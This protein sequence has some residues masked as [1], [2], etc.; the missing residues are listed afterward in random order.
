MDEST[1]LAR[2]Q[3][4][5]AAQQRRLADQQA[6]LGHLQA[7]LAALAGGSSA[8]SAAHAA[9]AVDVSDAAP[10][11]RAVTRRR[12]LGLAAAGVGGAALVSTLGAEP[13][14]ANDPN[15]VTIASVKTNGAASATGLDT[16]ASL[17]GAQVL[18]QSGSFWQPTSS[19]REAALAGWAS[20]GGTADTGV[21]AFSEIAGGTGMFAYSGDGPGII[22][23]GGESALQLVS[24]GQAGPPTGSATLGDVQSCSD[25][26]WLC[27]AGGAT[28]TWRKV[29]GSATAGAFH[30]ITPARVY[31]SRIVGA[32][33]P[34]K[35]GQTRVVS[36]A[37]EISSTGSI[38]ATDIVPA[39]ATAIV[40]NLTI[41]KMV[42]GPG[43]LS[44]TP[45]GGHSTSS[46]NWK[47]ADVSLANGLTTKVNG[48][49]QISV[50]AQ[51]ETHFLLDVSGYYL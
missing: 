34:I 8:R 36:V 39:G 18:F 24:T 51:N 40:A 9:S 26:V 33:T 43:Y 32:K 14:L 35:A 41:T 31:D 25:G 48:S 11:H 5:L 20:Q 1:E 46:I 45:S 15:D 38:A 16:T 6:E 42:T 23:Q 12:L 4:E 49:R 29:Q 10:P 19:S 7:Q 22:A 17:S 37:N 50:Y 21:Y 28:P 47:F 27:V 44:V 3:L 30:A 2:L 13:A